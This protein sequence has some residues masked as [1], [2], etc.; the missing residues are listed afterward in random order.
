MNY[1]LIRSLRAKPFFTIQQLSRLM[2]IK[3][4]SARVL[5][6]RYVKKGMFV[7]LKNNLYVLDQN[8]LS[9]AQADFFRLANVLQVPSYVSFMSALAFYGITTQVPR[10]FYECAALKRSAKYEVK[11]ILFNFYKLKP[12]LYFGFVKQNDI[13]IAEPEK[14]LVDAMYLYSFGKYKMDLSSLDIGK[15]SKNKLKRILKKFPQKTM[16]MVSKLCKI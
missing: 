10:D 16:D 4:A 14:A 11:G 7:R 8:W 6:V 9:L 3:P 15:L 5:C 1:D 13:F 12:A 2:R